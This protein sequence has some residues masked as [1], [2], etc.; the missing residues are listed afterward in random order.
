MSIFQKIIDGEM[1]ADIVYNDDE[2]CA[3]KDIS[4]KA[5]VHILVIPKKPIKSLSDM[6]S[7]DIQLMGTLLFRAKQIAAEQGLTDYRLVTNNGAQA[8]QSVYHIHFHILGGRPMG[9]PPG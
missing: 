5:P 2:V 7:D 8:G 1:P 3:F 4:P 6:S 9:W